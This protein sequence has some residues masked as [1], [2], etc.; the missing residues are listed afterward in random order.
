[1]E[2]QELMEVIT[3]LVGQVSEN[4]VVVAEDTY[5]RNTQLNA[6]EVC[7]DLSSL[8]LVQF[9]IALEERF[10]ISVTNE[11]LIHFVQVKDILSFIQRELELEQN[12]RASIESAATEIFGD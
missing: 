3:E 2:K 4:E 9:V 11:E 5:V 12:R 7:L 1:M 8:E 10:Q 6:G